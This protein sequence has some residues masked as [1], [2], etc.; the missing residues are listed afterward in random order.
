M[1][2]VLLKST[3]GTFKFVWVWVCV[4]RSGYTCNR[5][6][7][8]DYIYIYMKCRQTKLLLTMVRNV[9]LK[10]DLNGQVGSLIG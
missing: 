9:Q 2:R 7:I 5:Q 10:L 6:K 8:V 1:K 3:P 4:C